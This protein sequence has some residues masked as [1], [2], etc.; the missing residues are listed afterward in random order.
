MIA[1]ACMVLAVLV[2]LCLGPGC[3]EPPVP[4]DPRSGDVLD[5]KYRPDTGPKQVSGTIHLR[6][7]LADA[8]VGTVY[9]ILRERGSRMPAR[10]R[11]YVYG[12][13]EISDP[14]D[15]ERRLQFVITER[16]VPPGMDAPLPK[17]PELRVLYSPTGSVG[18]SGPQIAKEAP[19]NYGDERV[20]IALP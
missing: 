11:S 19:V 6:G 3:G 20:E 8:E 4:V 16:D 15:G 13:V 5:P 1:R 12:G 2:G 18:G 9:V 10:M 14:K 7:E 17:L